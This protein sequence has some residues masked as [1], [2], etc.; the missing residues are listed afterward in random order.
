VTGGV[1]EDK[2]AVE[3]SV[4]PTL[5]VVERQHGREPAVGVKVA[6][7]DLWRDFLICEDGPR[8]R[9]SKIRE[10]GSQVLVPVPGLRGR[11][12]PLQARCGRD[13]DR[14]VGDQQQK[15]ADGQTSAMAP[16]TKPGSSLRRLW[17]QQPIAS[18]RV[19]DDKRQEPGEIDQ[20]AQV[21]ADPDSELSHAL[22]GDEHANRHYDDG[23]EDPGTP[24]T[25]LSSNRD[26]HARHDRHLTH[27][28]A[29]ELDGAES[30]RRHRESGERRHKGVEPQDAEVPQ[31]LAERHR[32]WRGR[33]DGP[34]C[35]VQDT[36]D[37][38]D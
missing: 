37:D 16:Q 29:Q 12:V 30:A 13:R 26:G 34:G 20:I 18:E 27:D 3:R 8:T 6:A 14:A 22:T 2:R 24:G 35:Q 36:P 7:D 15:A 17:D 33:P 28:C 23:R 32:A 9:A 10:P 38:E 1:E 19:A 21:A 31:V 11:P 4:Y 25:R 5:R